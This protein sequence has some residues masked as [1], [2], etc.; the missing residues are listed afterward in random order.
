M[1]GSW[2]ENVVSKYQGQACAERFEDL[3]YPAGNRNRSRGEPGS[4]AEGN[5]DNGGALPRPGLPMFC[6]Q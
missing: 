4:E 6:K 1:N 5:T 3:N 2:D